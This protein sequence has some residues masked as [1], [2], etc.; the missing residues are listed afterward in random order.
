MPH[1][2][3]ATVPNPRTQHHFIADESVTHMQFGARG[4]KPPVS[5]KW[6]EGGEKPPIR[7]EWGI[8]EFKRTG[9]LMIGDK[10]TLMTGGR[11]NDPVLLLSDEE[12][13]DFQKNPPK[14]TIPRVKEEAPVD[15]WINAMKNNRLPGSHF[16]YAAELTEMAL[17]G[18][19]AQRFAA[20]IE[21]DAKNMKI[22]NRPDIDAY[23]KEPAREGWSYGE[24]L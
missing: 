7:P 13:K 9:M 1:T 18:V 24:S 17:V 14:K 19:L 16:G 20:K 2:V 15:E 10:K 3:E 22:T 4:N 8:K 5:L 23:I 6:Y 11:P 12:W 21:Y